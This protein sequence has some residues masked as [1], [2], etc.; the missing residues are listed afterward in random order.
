MNETLL[1]LKAAPIVEAVLDID[2]DMPLTMDV[3]ALETPARAVYGEKYPK[4]QPQFMQEFMFEAPAEGSAKVTKSSLGI[5]ALQFLQDDGK[6]LVQVRAQGYSFNRLAPYGS[7]DDYL[8]EMERTWHLFT[9]I[10]QPVKVNTVRLRYIN[11]LLLPFETGRIELD[12]Y[13]VHGPR[14]PL[15][16]GLEF[17]GF[18]HQ[19]S[20]VEAETGNQVHLVLAR[21]PPEQEKYP[22]IFDIQ[23]FHSGD[24]EPSDWKG[25]LS[26]VESLRRLKNLVFRKSLTEKCL[27]LFR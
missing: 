27:N 8:P 20:A 21:Q 1:H 16:A 14:L 5:Q 9:K 22:V 12:E 15:D 13:L 17:T 25:I 2:C 7:L 3:A 10:A 6:Q 4:F 18:V 11:R 23:T 19:H 24:M 26:R